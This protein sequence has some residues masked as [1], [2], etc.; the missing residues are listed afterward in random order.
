[1]VRFQNSPESTKDHRDIAPG[2]VFSG[3]QNDPV[4]ASFLSPSLSAMIHVL[5]PLSRWPSLLVNTGTPLNMASILVIYRAGRSTAYNYHQGD[6]YE[7]YPPDSA[8]NT[9][10]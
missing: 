7:L 1:M 2:E 6:Y 10:V 5:D 4:S 3:K 9:R 8:Y